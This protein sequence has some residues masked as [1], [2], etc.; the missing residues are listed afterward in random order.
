[1]FRQ[2]HMPS[3]QAMLVRRGVMSP[4]HL[5]LRNMEDQEPAR[6][7]KVGQIAITRQKQQM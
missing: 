6:V 2:Q 7:D 5:R 4:H 3:A 1:M